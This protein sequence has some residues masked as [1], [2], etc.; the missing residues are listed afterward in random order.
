MNPDFQPC[1]DTHMGDEGQVVCVF[2]AAD[3]SQVMTETYRDGRVLV[4][5]REDAWST[6]SAPQE[7]ISVAIEPVALDVVDAT[8]LD[9]AVT[10][11]DT[12]WLE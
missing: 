1:I 4:R 3:G 2:Q 9:A 10:I 12:G 11:A 6:W 8:D 7:L 5:S